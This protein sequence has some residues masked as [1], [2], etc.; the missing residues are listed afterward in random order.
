MKIVFIRPNMIN[1]RQSDA[2]EP[3]AFSVLAGLTPPDV[4]MVLFDD[5]VEEI[6]YHVDADLI[7]ISVETFTAKRAYHIAG[8]FREQGIPVVMGGFHPT[9]LPDEALDFAD[10]VVIGDAEPVW[11]Q[12]LEDFKAKSLKKKYQGQLPHLNGTSFPRQIFNGKNYNKLTP[13]QYSRGCKFDCDFCSISSF[14]GK[15][16]I[17]R[18][19]D[20]V[21]TE[22]GT[23]GAKNIFITDDNIFST[24]TKAIELFKALLPL[25]IN[26]VCQV[27]IDIANDEKLLQ[28]MKKSGC[29][30]VLIGF[31]SLETNNLIQMGKRVNMKS[32]YGT[33]IKKIRDNG[34]MIFGTFVLGY[35]FDTKDSFQKTLDLA[36]ESKFLIAQFN[37]LMP[38]PGTRLYSRLKKENRLIYDK[39]WLDPRFKWGDA[40]FV[41]KL[42]TSDELTQ[43]CDTM[44]KQFY[45]YGSIFKRAL[46][47]KANSAGFRNLMLY[48]FMNLV[49]KKEVA[50]KK[51][52]YLGE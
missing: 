50:R 43:G 13:V 31:E 24:K 7:A 16:L 1:E 22:I 30:A 48:T 18:S 36:L 51:G 20:S 41:P 19:I 39:W 9:F 8:R 26:W 28:L 10:T 12:V 35:D 45:R 14:Y 33:V 27:S 4:E 21:V 3:L 5:R 40:M 6:D 52:R 15:T 34:I 42:M 29:V 17:T 44:R 11:H 47:L 23:T 37:P 49:S 2:L 25:N 32:D 46:D 38:M